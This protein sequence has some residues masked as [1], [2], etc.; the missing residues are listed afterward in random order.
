VTGTAVS[1]LQSKQEHLLFERFLAVPTR[2]S[3][4]GRLA[5]RLDLDRSVLVKTQSVPRSKHTS[6]QS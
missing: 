2:L 1:L 3:S 6:S 5:N 4:E